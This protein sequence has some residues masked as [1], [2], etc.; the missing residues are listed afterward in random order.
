MAEAAGKH[1]GLI[2][3]PTVADFRD[4]LAVST[5]ASTAGRWG[6]GLLLFSGG[7]GTFVT[8][9]SSAVDGTVPTA[10]VLVMLATAALGL[11]ALP[12]LQARRLHRRAT[13]QG[14]HRTVL[15]TW[16]VTITTTRGSER[17]TRWSEIPS[18]EERLL[19]R[20]LKG[21]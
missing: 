10:Q 21:G 6:R 12:W 13:A 17:M 9:A 16:G 7:A 18:Y 4:A 19:E 11:V 8:V 5:R 2:Y 3:R 14:L 20:R 1:V 15:D